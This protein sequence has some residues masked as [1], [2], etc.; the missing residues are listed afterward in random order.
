[1]TEKEQQAFVI[2]KRRLPLEDGHHGGAW[3][4]AFADFMT[5][6]MAL[7]L[8]LWLI[9]STSEKTKHAVAQYF[10]PVKLVDVTTLKKGFRDPKN[11]E[12]AAGPRSRKSSPE[13]DTNKSL[14]ETR[15][16]VLQPGA[17]M[18]TRSEATLF[19]DPYAVLA[20][21]AA[22]T[23]SAVKEDEKPKPVSGPAETAA[24]QASPDTFPTFTDPFTTIPREAEATSGP[25]PAATLQLSPAAQAPPDPSPPL[26]QHEHGAPSP[27]SEAPPAKPDA[28]IKARVA[29][30]PPPNMAADVSDAEAN[31]LKSAVA[32]L[33][34]QDARAGGGPQIEV[35]STSE[36]LLISLT[37][38]RNFSMFAVGSAEPQPKTVE[39][40]ARI[41]EILKTG[42]G[43]VIV[44]GHTDGRPFRSATY[45]N[46]RLS[47]AR[48][49]MAHYMLVRGGLDER[50][51]EKIE[52][53]ADH[54]LKVPEDPMAPVNRRIEIL[55]RK[56]K[57]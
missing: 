1:M 18:P 57:S 19:R 42:A 12:M 2:V 55:L 16:V 14:A 22:N 28:E 29:S 47:A 49:H 53:Y 46:W 48:A 6:M 54:R 13:A 24:P 50:R 38:D 56:E 35:Q 32:A 40:M 36:G 9:S 45:D 8:V 27:V 25:D 44:R 7:F 37:D 3:K 31:R 11:T 30:A 20:E 26:D 39:V 33:A 34:K 10:N 41:G 17:K 52:G 23:Q 4:I 21:I 5:A 51:I 15:E 43:A